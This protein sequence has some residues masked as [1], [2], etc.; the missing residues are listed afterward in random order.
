M[1]VRG[2][3]DRVIAWKEHGFITA[4][5]AQKIIDFENATPA[6]SWIAYGVSA[7]G[8]VA[9]ATGFISLVAANWESISDTTKLAIYFII[10]ASLGFGFLR[11]ANKPGLS[12]EVFLSLFGLFILAGIGLV[13]QIFHLESDGWQGLRFWLIL[14]LLP[15]LL[16]QSRFLPH[17]WFAGLF[18]TLAIWYGMVHRDFISDKSA[19]DAA[20]IAGLMLPLAFTYGVIAV[21]ALPTKF[22]RKYFVEAAQ[23]WGW[24][25]LLGA[26]ATV[27][28]VFWAMPHVSGPVFPFSIG[29]VPFVLSLV[30]AGIYYFRSRIPEQR[31]A[32]YILMLLSPLSCFL[33]ILPLTI[34]RT[35]YQTLGIFF[36]ILEFSLAAAA[37]A[38]LNRKRLFDLATFIIAT[39]FIVAYFE[40]F[41]SLA[42]TGIGLIISGIVILGAVW[43]W[44]KL[45][46]HFVQLLARKT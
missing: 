36:F 24:L 40:V 42:A 3:Q 25:I 10:Q 30:A 1:A 34:Q 33:L 8:L 19:R 39:R 31:I 17:I 32:V 11:T 45:R 13:G 23:I 27:T 15:T 16:A 14:S 20:E 7:I 43:C 41:G 2:L 12:R 5:Q 46:T 21:G 6:R 28:N 37:A 44:Y 22:G 18:A 9:I 29:I 38:L 35:G 4:E 26:V